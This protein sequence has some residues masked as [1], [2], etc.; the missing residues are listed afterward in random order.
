MLAAPDTRNAR[1]GVLIVDPDRGDTLYSR[2]AGKLFVP[3]SNMKIVTSAIAL[4]TLGPDF[5]FATPILAGGP[6]RDSVIDGDLLVVGR[7]DPGVSDHVAGDA[8]LPLRAIAD[9]LWERGIR[10]IRG[11]V[12]PA[13]DA[14]PDAH[15]G[16][17]WGWDDL[18]EPYGATVDELLFNEGFAEIRVTAGPTPGD[19]VSVRL[20]PATS[21]PKLRVTA[22]TVVRG[23]G[24][25]SLHQLVAV[26]DTL[27]GDVVVSG[28]IPAGDSA[29]LTVTFRDPREAYVHALAEALRDRGIVIGDSVFAPDSVGDTVMVA[30]SPPLSQVLGAFM[31]PSQNQIG[32]MLF[33]AIALNRADTG[34]ARVAR[35][36]FTEQ[37]RAWGAEPDGFIIW[38][39]SGLSRRDLLTPETVVRVLA[40]MRGRANYQT[41]FDAFPVAG[42]DGTLETRMRGTPAEANVR[43]KTGTLGNVRSLSGYVTTA[44]G[45]QLIFSVLSNNYLTSTAYIS[46]VQDSIAVRLARLRI[47]SAR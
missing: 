7:G 10:G 24:R 21:F 13:G 39:G 3:A 20:T 41:F 18:D 1:W 14:F 17:G 33:K 9:S 43:A 6:V 15:A 40:T 32:E 47:R 26:K 37:L 36:L 19:S 45:G 2:D 5:R 16:F 46:R 27:R 31:K 38:D 23:T 12:T 8:M 34:S 28:T 22:S 44:G 11:R 29:R 30:Y 25:D 35:R 42:V 4:E